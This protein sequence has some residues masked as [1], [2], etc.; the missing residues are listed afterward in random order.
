MPIRASRVGVKK[1]TGYQ[2]RYTLALFF[3]SMILTGCIGYFAALKAAS[4]SK[5][6]KEQVVVGSFDTVSVPVPVAPVAPG[7]LLKDLTVRYVKF[8]KHQ[9][10]KG[11]L[12]NFSGL[13]DR[14][15]TTTLPASLP[16]FFENLSS[17]QPVNN[18][19]SARIPSGMRAMTID[20]TATS[21]VEGWAGSGSFVDVLL[22]T[23]KRTS[24]IAEKVKILSAE[25]VVAAIEGS[26]SVAVPRTVTLLV[27]Q[28]QCLAISTALPHGKISF[29]L[30]NQS[31]EGIWRSSDLDAEKIINRNLVSKKVNI[32]G[33]LKVKGVGGEV[34]SYALRDNQ[35]EIVKE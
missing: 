22:V 24:V 6:I 4:F 17:E 2:S 14:Y 18:P 10:P 35:W 8:P 7:T 25:R 30:R 31:D 5:P 33:V 29:A 20:V 1:L 11:A 3:L 28:E 19:V 32:S 12:L 9:L 21:S 15:V 34:K 26:P 27:T 13:T 16:I 23:P